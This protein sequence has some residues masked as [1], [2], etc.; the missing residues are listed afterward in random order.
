MGAKWD[1]EEEEAHWKGIA[2]DATCTPLECDL[3]LLL[4]PHPLFVCLPFTPILQ[5]W[6]DVYLAQDTSYPFISA[7]HVYSPCLG[8]FQLQSLSLDSSYLFKS[9]LN[10]ISPM[11]P[12]SLPGSACC[13]I[14]C[15]P[16]V[17]WSAVLSIGYVRYLLLWGPWWQGPLLTCLWILCP[18]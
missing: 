13:H 16:S 2:R 12:A 5:Q 3:N 11:K 10:V 8:L 18:T 17:L 7:S 15:V 1:Y 9:R 6:L 14:L 4:Q